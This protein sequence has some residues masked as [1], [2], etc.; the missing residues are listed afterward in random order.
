MSYRAATYEQALKDIREEVRKAQSDPGTGLIGMWMEYQLVFD[1]I[2]KI[3]DEALK[4]D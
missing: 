1:R 4:R 3:T 2:A